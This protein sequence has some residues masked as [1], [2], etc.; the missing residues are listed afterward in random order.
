M[1]STPSWLWPTVIIGSIA[2]IALSIAAVVFAA[3]LL[4]AASTEI[5]VKTEQGTCTRGFGVS[6]TDVAPELIEDE[7]GMVL[8]EG[9]VIEE[10]DYSSF[11][12]SI[13]RARF[14][15]PA[16]GVAEWEGSLSQF[17]PAEVSDKC[18][19]TEHH[20]GEISC[21][22]GTDGTPTQHSWRWYTR[23]TRPDGSVLVTVDVV[24]P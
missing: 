19:G 23:S 7:T 4:F 15:I 13:L 20:S 10:S 2:W 16:D 21:A 6:C 8:P 1:K 14:I 18:Q 5:P 3:G 9:T 11:Q 17:Q 24:D 22:E 12:D